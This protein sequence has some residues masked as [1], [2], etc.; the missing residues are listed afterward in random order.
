MKEDY[1]HLPGSER[2][3]ALE[4]ENDRLWEIV[5]AID[6]ELVMR[7]LGVCNGYESF[8]EAR[9]KIKLLMDWAITTE[10]TDPP[11]VF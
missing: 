11:S 8:D 10:N 3:D 9:K 5:R 1:E 4:M 2:I 7:E 6:H